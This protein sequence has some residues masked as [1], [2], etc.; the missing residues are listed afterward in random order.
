MPDISPRGARL[1]H[2]SKAGDLV[3]EAGGE[4][5]IVTVDETLERAMLEAKQIRLEQLNVRQPS[6]ADTLPIS[7]IQQLIRAGADPAKVA[8][9]YGLA[10]ALVRRF[11]ASVQT[12]KQYAIEQFKRVPAP[13]GS[14]V[15]T[16][17]E[18]IAATLDMAGIDRSTLT[19]AATRR[20][21]EP[22]HIIAQ[23]LSAGR[24]VHAEWTWNMHDN[25]VVCLNAAARKL[26]GEQ[27]LTPKAEASSVSRGGASRAADAPAA[28]PATFP[29]D[30]AAARTVPGPVPEPSLPPMRPDA[31][32]AAPLSPAVT[33]D[34][35]L[36]RPV[37]S[38]PSPQGAPAAPAASVTSEG[39]ATPVPADAGAAP[40]AETPSEGDDRPRKAPK[41]RSGRSAVP[42]WDE[43]LFGE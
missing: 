6:A 33:G 26:L 37:V 31:A 10:E 34:I 19:W 39:D 2:V 5:F 4:R 16:V 22:W 21:H 32:D 28:A 9:R 41:R 3:F 11:S 36:A 8:E 15:R 30:L 7:K 17:E 35:P 12:E 20:G 25:T 29:V 13:K 42:S 43:I 14:R 23:F 1:D 18:L 40:A 27:E 38:L 24:K